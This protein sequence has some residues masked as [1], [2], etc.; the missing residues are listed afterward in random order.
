MLRDFEYR[1][2]ADI[3][4]EVLGRFNI[5]LPEY[6]ALVRF[7]VITPDSFMWRLLISQ[8]VY[9]LYAE[10]YVP[11]LGHIKSI[12][13]QYVDKDDWALVKPR[14]VIQFDDATPVKGATT[15]NEPDDSDDMMQY[16][17]DSGHDFVFLVRSSEDTDNAQFSD[18]A[19]RGFTL[20]S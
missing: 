17:V 6:I 7:E 11:G 13:N 12:F 2:D 9:Y 16:A 20:G 5:D 3:I 8:N 15:Y 1:P 4:L 19:P 18:S 10:D 14:R